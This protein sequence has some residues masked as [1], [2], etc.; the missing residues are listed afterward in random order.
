M[1]S[2]RGV[3]VET[4]DELVAAGLAIKKSERVGRGRPVEITRMR[5]RMLDGESSN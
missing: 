4:I 2:A 3:K 1:L 5:S